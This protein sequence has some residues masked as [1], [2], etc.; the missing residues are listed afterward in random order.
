MA[1]IPASV[2]TFRHGLFPRLNQ[3]ARADASKVGDYHPVFGA[4]PLSAIMRMPLSTGPSVTAR[5]SSNVAVVDHQHV[6][7]ALVAEDR[8]IGVSPSTIRGGPS[9]MR[10]RTNMPG[11]SSRSRFGMLQ[12]TTASC[13]YL[14]VELVLETFQCALVGEAF[15]VG[16][17]GMRR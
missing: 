17:V 5:R 7:P 11:R 6:L 14:E 9:V 8:L 1:P 3:V 13:R 10:T 16:P 4:Q 12:R 2:C 15:F